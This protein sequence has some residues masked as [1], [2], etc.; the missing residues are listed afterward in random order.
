MIGD[1]YIQTRNGTVGHKKLRVLINHGFR[2]YEIV[3][4]EDDSYTW[5]LII[6]YVTT[7]KWLQN[8]LETQESKKNVIDFREYFSFI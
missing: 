8:V 4:S 2:F 7:F 3:A 5:Q 6:K 1:N